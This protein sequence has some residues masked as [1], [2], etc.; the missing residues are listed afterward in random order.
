MS[1]P[2]RPDDLAERIA[3]LPRPLLVALDVD[4]TLAPIVERPDAA[5]VPAALRRALESLARVRGVRLALVTG[6]DAPSLRKVAPVR[7]VWRA[8]EHG[9]RIIA[10]GERTRRRSLSSEERKKLAAFRDHLEAEAAPAGARIEDK[11]GA[12]A[13][14]VRALEAHDET[15]ADRIL[16]RAT[17]EAE[18]IGLHPRMG[19][20]V[21]EA[22]LAPGDKGEALGALF[23]RTRA[24]SVVYAGDDLT[25]YPAIR[26]ATELGGVGLFVRSVERPRVPRGATA[27]VDGPAAVADLVAEL[28]VRLKKRR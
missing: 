25:D 4:G 28:A 17:R 1:R 24:E 14:H 3:R 19:R 16:A 18:R 6:R 15:R 22:E 10:P 12:V 2:P 5:R 9:G 7:G 20:A 21:C 8:V 11:D 26:K 27:A 13:V 23:E